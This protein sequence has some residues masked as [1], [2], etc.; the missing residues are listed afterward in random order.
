MIGRFV[1]ACVLA[2]LLLPINASAQD[3]AK[4]N[5]EIIKKAIETRFEGIKV[6]GVTKTAYGGLYEVRTA[7]GELFYTDDKVNFIVSGSIIDGKTRENVTEERKRKLSAIKF[8]TLP[9]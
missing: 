2:G 3:A 9:L 7:G 6:D 5:A 4:V 8:D 1:T